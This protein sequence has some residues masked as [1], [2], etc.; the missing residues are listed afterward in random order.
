MSISSAEK[1]AIESYLNHLFPDQQML[2]YFFDNLRPVRFMIWYGPGSNGK[3]TFR[4]LLMNHLSLVYVRSMVNADEQTPIERVA[5]NYSTTNV[6]YETNEV[7]VLVNGSESFWSSVCPIV[8][9]QQDMRS[10]PLSAEE[11][12]ALPWTAYLEQRLASMVEGSA[13]IETP[14]QSRKLLKKMKKTATA[15]ATAASTATAATTE[16]KTTKKPL[17]NVVEEAEV[18]TEKVK[19]TIVYEN[20][21]AI[22]PRIEEDTAAEW[23]Y[24]DI[25][26]RLKRPDSR[27]DDV[28]TIS[29]DP[30]SDNFIVSFEQPAHESWVTLYMPPNKLNAYLPTF[31]SASTWDAD[32]YETVEFNVPFFSLTTVE[33][34]NVFTYATRN[35]LPQIAF[36][37]DDW[38]VLTE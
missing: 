3:T 2:N 36:H 19:N 14:K 31:F 37:L 4:N 10:F 11:V 17:L 13:P 29:P 21:N 22:R 9:E 18:N 6:I 8:F 7:P 5:R 15:T 1:F 33:R 28:L 35:L 38:P 32:P 20:P 26:I 12:N 16:D 25:V 27:P 23:A 34:E 30:E 24:A